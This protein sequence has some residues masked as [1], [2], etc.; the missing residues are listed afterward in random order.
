MVI[1]VNERH[2]FQLQ[3]SIFENE[4]VTSGKKQMQAFSL[5][6]ELADQTDGEVVCSQFKGIWQD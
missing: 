1:H 3:L 6:G 2:F 5:K 4:W